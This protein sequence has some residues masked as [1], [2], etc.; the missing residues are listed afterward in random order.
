MKVLHIINAVAWAVN[1]ILWFFFA[2]VPFMGFASVTAA[3]AAVYLARQS[4]YVYYR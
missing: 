1:A 3:V 2:K 4:D